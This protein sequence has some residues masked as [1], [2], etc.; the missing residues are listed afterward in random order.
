[1]ESR[2]LDAPDMLAAL[3]LP[4]DVSEK[5]GRLVADAASTS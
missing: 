5:L 2:T 4:R 3:M 1:M